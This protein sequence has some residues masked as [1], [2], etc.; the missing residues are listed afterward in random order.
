MAMPRFFREF[1]RPPAV[2]ETVYIE[3]QDGAHIRRSLRM[4]PGAE[5]LLCDGRGREYTAAIDGFEGDTVR[6]TVTGIAENRT[7]PSV[8][9]T[10]YQGLP[11]GDKLEWIIQ[12]AVELGA[13]EIVPVVTARSIAK[14]GERA[15]QKQG[16]HQ[17]IAAEAAGQC[18]R[19]RIP[20]VLLPIPFS[21][22]L[23]RIRQ[24]PTIVCYE[25]GGRPL[26]EL[27]SP[28]QRELSL[29]IGPEG[30]FSPQ[31]VEALSDAG[32]AVATLGRRILRCET[33]PIAAMTAVMLLTG[34]LE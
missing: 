15:A 9:V 13:A 11:K 12:K 34:N 2:G 30:G 31:E 18:G 14:P 16:R 23:R 25:A 19:G 21:E 26:R 6:L 28:G 33:A 4:A 24:E 3:G 32:A 1:D 27:V 10:L 20:A 8:R 22:A 7:E 17:K 29:F 5:L